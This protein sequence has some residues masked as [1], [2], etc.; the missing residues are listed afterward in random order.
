MARMA[1]VLLMGVAIAL[2]AA[3]SGAPAPPPTTTP[4]PLT[5]DAVYARM[6]EAVAASP[7][8]VM[9]TETQTGAR[10]LRR[11]ADI[12]FDAGA[13]RAR[14]EITADFGDGVPKPST[15]IIDG[16]SWYQ[17]VE[18]GETRVREA[19]LCRDAPTPALALLGGCRSA[20]ER[21]T[22]RAEEG[23][24]FEGRAAVALVSEGEDAGAEQ[25]LTF[26]ARLYVDAGDGLPFA[27]VTEGSER[28]IIGNGAAT[29][30]REVSRFIFDAA[31][32][33]AGAFAPASIGYAGGPALATA[34]LREGAAAGAELFW[35]GETLAAPLALPPLPLASAS[36][37][38]GGLEAVVG[39]RAALTYAAS[40]NFGV[41]DV[42]LRLSSRAAI[43]R[44][45]RVAD[46]VGLLPLGPDTFVE[47]EIAESSAWDSPIGRAVLLRALRRVE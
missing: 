35:A 40:G 15:W 41:P 47:I 27:A 24:T 22:T 29:P 42:T 9:T 5:A 18:G 6:R 3:C 10:T 43:A 17:T 34:A 11:T 21:T 13:S 26:V 20:F 12:R 45:G 23:A 33:A 37:F 4:A 39:Y 2:S 31:P 38:G 7:H 14:V 30:Y 28:A 36:V 46:G 16:R 44:A 19:L 1:A 8:V 25:R 32:P